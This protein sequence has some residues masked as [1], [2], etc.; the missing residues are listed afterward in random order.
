MSDVHVSRVRVR[1]AET[2]QMGVL[3][4]AGWVVY[5]EIGRTDLMRA[6]GLS[7]RK[8]EDELGLML[9]VVDFGARMTASAAYDDEVEIRTRVGEIG[10]VKV[11]FEYEGYL[12]GR[13]L[14]TGYSV[15]GV[16]NRD[17]KITRLPAEV[18]ALLAK[19]MD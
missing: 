10:R 6:R 15:H 4:H 14:A 1:Y 11:R 16:V 2:D 18:T 3:H 8:L 12:D 17:W 19:G 13:R 7:Y 9:P 5:W